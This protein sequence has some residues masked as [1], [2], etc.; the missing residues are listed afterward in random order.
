MCKICVYLLC[1]LSVRL[2]VN[3]WLLVV[4]FGG[5]KVYMWIFHCLGAGGGTQ[6]VPMAGPCHCSRVNHISKLQ[7][8]VLELLFPF[9]IILIYFF[10]FAYHPYVADS[11][12]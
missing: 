9:I 12:R 3:S 8:S 10:G 2:L 11:Q 6:W 5:V 1:I 4:K 7:G